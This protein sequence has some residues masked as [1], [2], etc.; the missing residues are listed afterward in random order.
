LEATSGLKGS[1]DIHMNLKPSS[2]FSS[3]PQWQNTFTHY[4]QDQGSAGFISEGDRFRKTGNSLH[5][6][7][8][9]QAEDKARKTMIN[10]GRV[11]RK[12]NVFGAFDDKAFN[13]DVAA[14]AFDQNKLNR[15]A[16]IVQNYERLCHSRVI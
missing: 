6:K 13:N 12:R 4:H 9:F 16:A 11:N 15:K 8:Q 3:T 5:I 10:E 14:D 7:N 1:S 2:R